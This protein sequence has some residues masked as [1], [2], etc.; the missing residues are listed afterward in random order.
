MTETAG[1]SASGSGG[2]ARLMA[3]L[4]YILFFLPML[5]H[6]RSEEAMFHAKQGLVLLI[7]SILGNVVLGLIPILGWIILPFFNLAVVVF[8]ILGL[9]NG[10][11]GKQVELPVIGSFAKNFKF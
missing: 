1:S 2:N 11:N 8:V 9:M 5:M 6:P 10:L 7:T 3:G 4:A